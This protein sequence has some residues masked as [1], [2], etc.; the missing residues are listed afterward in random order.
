MSGEEK[1]IDF[2]YWK[3]QEPPKSGQL[4]T[5]PLFPPNANSLLGLDSN[6]KVID[7]KAYNERAREINTN[8]IGFARAST[9][10]G[11][12]YKLIVIFYLQLQI[13]ANF[14]L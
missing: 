11:D 5:D 6:G 4:Y 8:Q 10:F 2:T 14:H 1:K 3:N 12:K 9:I 13:Y 7:S